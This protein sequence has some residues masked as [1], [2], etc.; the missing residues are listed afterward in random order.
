M[1]AETL[2]IQ[3]ELESVTNIKNN[4]Q[5]QLKEKE[6]SAKMVNQDL[7]RTNSEKNETGKLAELL[8]KKVQEC[9][10]TLANQSDSFVEM[11]R[12]LEENQLKIKDLEEKLLSTTRLQQVQLKRLEELSSEKAQIWMEKSSLSAK[13]SDQIREKSSL[14]KDYDLV[15]NDI[16]N[17]ETLLSELTITNQALNNELIEQKNH[18]KE[19]AE[20]MSLERECLQDSL[21]DDLAS[22]MVTT[23]MWH[24]KLDFAMTEICSLKA[25]REDMSA[26]ASALKE[27][28]NKLDQLNISNNSKLQEFTEEVELKNNELQ[29][30]ENNLNLQKVKFENTIEW[31]RKEFSLLNQ[32]HKELKSRFNIEIN[33]FKDYLKL[34]ETS[35]A[36]K[37]VLL[38]EAQK[39][40]TLSRESCDHLKSELTHMAIHQSSVETALENDRKSFESAKLIYEERIANET[41]EKSLQSSENQELKSKVEELEKEIYYLKSA[42][43]I[44]Q[45]NENTIQSLEHRKK[46]KSDVRSV[47]VDD[48]HLV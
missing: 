43:S 34:L 21:T 38:E 24:T 25:E 12:S 36:D 41:R 37:N 40:L 14:K 32:S 29:R 2:V 13:L 30:F 45:N 19:F 42:K 6:E 47:D 16:K 4:L 20:K 39:N 28:C 17:K 9:E 10:F 44:E 15:V 35:M 5:V 23:T 1:Q 8:S 46:R 18:F 48:I 31:T 11:N 7:V 27:K 26:V 3:N 22:Q 33:E